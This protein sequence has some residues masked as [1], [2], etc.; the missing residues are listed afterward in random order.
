MKAVYC[1]YMN[2][3]MIPLSEAEDPVFA[4]GMLGEG[5]A[6][7]PSEGRLYSPCNGRVDIVFETGHAVTLVSAEGSEIL[8]HIGIDTVKLNGKY[9]RPAVEEGQTVRKG[10]LLMEFD[11][12]AIEAEGYRTTTPMVICNTGDYSAVTPLAKGT[13]RAGKDKI[14]KVEK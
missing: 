1:A 13:V 12:E 8:L 2:G 3:E 11:L 9:F 14:L 10:E 5:V 4:E 6:V 7:R